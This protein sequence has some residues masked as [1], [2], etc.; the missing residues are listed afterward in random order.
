MKK[1]NLFKIVLTALFTALVYVATTLI[2]IPIPA[3]GGY[4]N[5]GDCFVVLGA[6]LLGPVYG[7]VAGGLGSALADL[8]SGYTQYALGTFIIKA[9][10]AVVAALIFKAFRSK[11]KISSPIGAVCAEIVMVLGYFVYESIFLGY[12]LGAAGAIVGNCIQAVAGAVSS[13]L[14]YQALYAVPAIKKFAF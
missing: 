4:M 9:G 14:L 12:G 7:A 5:L 8:L 13:V 6:F 3:T 2:Q 11:I 10:M 1:E